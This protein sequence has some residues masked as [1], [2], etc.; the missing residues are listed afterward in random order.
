[1]TPV[2]SSRR[3]GSASSL[4]RNSILH[5]SRHEFSNRRALVA[6]DLAEQKLDAL[7]VSCGLNIRYLTGFTGSNGVLLMFREGSLLLT[8]P[9]Y[10]VQ[11]AEETM[12]S[13]K[14][15]R[16]SLL[17]ALA[18]PVRSRRI[19]RLGFEKARLSFESY[20]MLKDNLPLG[21]SL[22]PVGGMVETRRM[23][24][25]DQEIA[26]IRQSAITTSRA[27]AQSLVRIRPGVQ[28]CHLAAR[29]EFGMRRFGAQK[30]AFETIVAGGPRSALPH[31][32]PTAN[33]LA[34]N[35]LLLIDMGAYQG[36]YASDMTRMVFFGRPGARVK[37][38]Y[39]A[40]LE[41]QLAAISAVREGV[42]AAEVDRQARRALKAENLDKAF[43]HST[44]HGLGL[45]IHELPRIARHDRTR[46][47]AGMVITIEPGVYLQGFGGIRIEDSVVVTR[48]GCEVLTPTPKEL[49]VL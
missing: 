40:V 5:L 33:I 2:L 29:L 27:F 1:M 25:S 37:R 28:E 43:V 4:S 23:V 6:A 3:K 42:T 14:V 34:S 21:T 35:Q 18:N 12:C 9:R 16:G 45:D 13:V 36:G 24:K 26:L 8:D 32:R 46:L 39:N 41:A 22:V 19:R 15:V 38:L 11:V 17:S 44:G 10:E 48:N 7:V 30:A 31:A 47:I 49:T 20:Q